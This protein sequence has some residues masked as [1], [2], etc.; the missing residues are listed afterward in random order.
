MGR[1]FSSGVDPD[2]RRLMSIEPGRKNV[3]V[4]LLDGPVALSHPDL[5][6]ADLR[7]ITVEKHSECQSGESRACHHGT[8][9]AG[10]L[11]AD[12]SSAG[13]GICRGCTVL[14]RP[15][16]AGGLE[17]GQPSA[18]PQELAQAIVESLRRGAHLINV[19]AAL[20]LAV[21]R[22]PELEAALELAGRHGALVIAAAGNEGTIGSSPL[23]RHPGVLPVAASDAARRPMPTSNLARSV[24]M[25]GIAAPGVVTSISPDGPPVTLSGTSFATAVVTGV[26]ALLWSLFHDLTAHDIARAVVGP[27]RRRSVSPPVLNAWAAYQRLMGVEQAGR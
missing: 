2:L 14:V 27:E 23:T 7:D 18:T 17:P 22:E 4:A 13:L 3:V 24:A 21:G 12:R 1:I 11:S 25:R 6:G 5:A 20:D 15:I 8:F 9:V 16:F 10:I 26:C 19:S